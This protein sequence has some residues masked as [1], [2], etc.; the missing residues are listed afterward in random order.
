MGYRGKLSVL[1][2]GLAFASCSHANVVYNWTQSAPADYVETVTGQIVVTDAAYRSGGLNVSYDYRTP[3]PNGF[4]IGNSPIIKAFLGFNLSERPPTEGG[5]QI[6]EYVSAEPRKPRFTTIQKKLD[7]D[8]TFTK[9]GLLSGT[10]DIFGAR[11]N[12]DSAGSGLSWLISDVNSDY[13]IDRCNGS[14]DKPCSG[15]T[16][17]W[18]V[19]ASTI[20]T[21][22]PEPA[23][24]ALFG[25][26]LTGMAGICFSR[27]RNRSGAAGV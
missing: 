16:G 1:A 20:P 13:F 24:W 11:A 27:R 5:S 18:M 2:A 12:F 17:Y 25:L 10:L 8:L 6:N 7:T 9:D 14:Y 15:G 26:A 21:D 23:G 22:V 19:D 3:R 4:T